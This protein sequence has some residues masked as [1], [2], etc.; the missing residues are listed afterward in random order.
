MTTTTTT[1]TTTTRDAAKPR[2]P[3][4]PARR[5]RRAF[6]RAALSRVCTMP[7]REFARAYGM[8]TTEVA[9]H[10]R[11]DDLLYH[12]RDNGSSV[13]AVAHL[14]TVSPDDE[15]AAHFADT[16]A[17]LVV[18][19]RALDDRLGAYIILEMLPRLGI[20]YDWLLTTGEESGQSTAGYFTPAK[21]Y[22][23]IIEFDRGGTDVVMYQYDD[24]DTRKAVRAAG[25]KVGDG[26]FS[27]ICYLEHLDVKGF[28]WGTGYRDYH[29]RRSHA[30]LED[31]FA[32]VGRYLR[33]H[34]AN[35]GLVMPHTSWEREYAGST[36]RCVVCQVTGLVNSVTL[37]CAECDSCQDCRAY[38]D[39][40]QCYVPD[41][42]APPTMCSAESYGRPAESGEAAAQL[43][44]AL[45]PV[46]A[47][48]DA[49]QAGFADRVTA[50][51]DQSEP[52]A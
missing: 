7:E 35:A 49:D 42:A 15:R 27:D 48:W 46:A 16:A 5:A 18:H 2:K 6:D 25:A 12:F 28:N 29:S 19:S 43:P 8:D 37:I 11:G 3:R 33:F 41:G 13:L 38:S 24:S 17:G 30:Y 47:G 52:A 10:Y 34:E 36:E 9:S 39:E 20:T 31:T 4:S 50:I 1:T 45:R 23:W 44:P 32:M 51:R 22:D 40:C 21:D 26:I 14:D